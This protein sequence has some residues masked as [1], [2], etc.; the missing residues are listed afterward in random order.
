M[1]LAVKNIY[2]RATNIQHQVTWY[3]ISSNPSKTQEAGFCLRIIKNRVIRVKTD[4]NL[5]PPSCQRLSHLI[6]TKLPSR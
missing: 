1:V 2:E 6:F 5:L 4:F 3:K